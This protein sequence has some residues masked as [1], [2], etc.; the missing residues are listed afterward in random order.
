[1]K[2]IKILGIILPNL[3]YGELS[4][5]NSFNFNGIIF[6]IGILNENWINFRKSKN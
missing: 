5:N 1:M 4:R 6:I 2:T 3:C